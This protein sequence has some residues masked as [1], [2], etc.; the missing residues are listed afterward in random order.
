MIPEH[1]QSRVID[2]GHEV[3]LGV[4]KSKQLLRQKV[5]FPGI[6]RMM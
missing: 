4:V 5:W 3:H 1:L 6:D 2:I